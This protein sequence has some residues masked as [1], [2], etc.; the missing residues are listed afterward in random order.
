MKIGLVC[1]G[2][3]ADEGLSPSTKKQFVNV[4]D[5]GI[6][7]LKCPRGHTTNIVLQDLRHELLFESGAI[8]L[9]DGYTRE[10]VASF[11]SSVER[12]TEF[13]IRVLARAAQIDLSK[14]WE[15]ISSN[16]ER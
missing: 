7:K 14:T 15:Q 3:I 16:S 5:S 1:P 8:A 2:C 11:A 9:I 4:E 10:A 6:Y 13:I 12:F